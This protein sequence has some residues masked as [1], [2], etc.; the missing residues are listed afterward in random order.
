MQKWEQ[1][2][3]EDWRKKRTKGQNS[4]T[5]FCVATNRHKAGG[6][7]EE[8][9]NPPPETRARKA[10]IDI[11][12]AG[13]FFRRG[14]KLV[15]YVLQSSSMSEVLNRLSVPFCAGHERGRG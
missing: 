5:Q 15:L 8:K 9:R 4:P 2:E 7:A 10:R 3:Q 11:W 13:I 1:G 12:H 6:S 14:A